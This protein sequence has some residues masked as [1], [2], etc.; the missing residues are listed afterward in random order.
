MR[1]RE[2]MPSLSFFTGGIEAEDGGKRKREGRNA[3]I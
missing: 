2:R 1:T 3:E